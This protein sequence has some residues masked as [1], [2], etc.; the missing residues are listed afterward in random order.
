MSIVLRATTLDVTGTL[1]NSILYQLGTGST[2]KIG[3]NEKSPLETL[4][5]NGSELVRGLFEM[6]TQNYAT[7][8]KGYN[9]QPLN[10][11]SSAFSSTI[12]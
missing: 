9:S 11:E 12:L 1:G 2:A 5:V 7:K 6:A 3:I 4:D 8:T 10:L